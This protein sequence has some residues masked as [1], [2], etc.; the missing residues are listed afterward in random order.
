VFCEKPVAVDVPGLKKVMEACKI[1]KEKNLSVLSGLCYRYDKPK[2]E[3]VKRIHDGAIGD[4]ITLQANYLTTGLWMKPRQSA[5][6]DMQWQLRNW[7]YFHWLSGDH[8]VE[9][10]I[11]SVDKMMWLMKDATPQK[12]TAAGGRVQRTSPEYGNI[13]DHFNAVFEWA[14]G[15]RGYF[16]C[17]QWNGT[18]LDVSD[19]AF[20]NKGTAALHVHQISGPNEW[21]GKQGASMY[22]L[23]HV[24]LFKAIRKNEPINNGDYMVNSTMASMMVRMS[25]YT[26]KT[27]YWDRAAAD[28]AKAP[29][30]APVAWES[31]EDLTPPKYEFGPLPVA[32]VAVPG[33][34]KFI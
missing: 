32:P 8:V 6:D 12:I 13:Y 25:A 3:A 4:I 15:Q 14:S 18:D 20:G 16:G 11:H 9:Q 22:D 24:A 30:D 33:T 26:G 7:L 19:Y 17:R 10:A 34:T 2:V 28:A 29:K 21:K 23:E 27:I 1:A 31:T 5:W